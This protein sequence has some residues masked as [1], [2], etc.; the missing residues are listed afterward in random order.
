MIE[1]EH[2]TKSFGGFVAVRG[3]CAAV[4]P[5]E[6]T[7][8][9]GPNGAG[10]TTLLRMITGFLAPTRGRVRVCGHDTL[11]AS[12]AAR[13]ALG[14][15]PET[16][17]AY[18]EMTVAG[19]LS[20]RAGLFGV[21]WRDRTRAVHD[22]I[23]RC[24]L[25][26]V[27]GKRVGHLSKGY[28]Q[29]TG[30]AAATLHNPPVL[31]LDEPTS[32][33]DPSQIT[34]M[35]ELV[36]GLARGERGARPR[37][38]LFSSHI[39]PEVEQTCDR[40]MIMAGGVVRADGTPAELVARL[41]PDA[42][43]VVRFAAGVDAGAA[44]GVMERALPGWRVASGVPTPG[45]WWAV[46]AAGSEVEGD[47]C[48]AVARAAGAAGAGGAGGLVL[49]ELR[50]ERPTLERVFLSVVSGLADGSAASAGVREGASRT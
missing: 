36:R 8:L 28:R 13:R 48:E 21:P 4:R 41:A 30:L 24:W 14:Y 9:L 6:A 19:F 27:A 31:V 11:T 5:G 22:A 35:R 32:G 43:V 45:A 46:P 44:R 1:V 49:S 2:A 16:V 26:E 29:R 3:V 47:P 39:L 42:A 10:K 12:M 33:L 23:E 25:G 34:Q 20:F 18:P 50:R 38:V 7:G 15:L 40:V 37:T 17:P